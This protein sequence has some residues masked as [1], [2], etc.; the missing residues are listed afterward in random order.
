MFSVLVR[1]LVRAASEDLGKQLYGVNVVCKAIG[2]GA[3]HAGLG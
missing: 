3:F 2:T 1:I